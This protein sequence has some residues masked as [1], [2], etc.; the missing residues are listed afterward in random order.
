M[1]PNKNKR[2]PPPNPK[3]FLMW[4]VKELTLPKALP[5][6]G[7]AWFWGAKLAVWAM[8]F[9]TL[10]TIMSCFNYIKPGENLASTCFLYNKLYINTS[11]KHI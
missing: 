6:D 9:A 3:K 7:W 10:S 1:K 8:D 5:S 2:T 4:V 11:P